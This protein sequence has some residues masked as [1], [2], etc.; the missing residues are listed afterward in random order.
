MHQHTSKNSR[1]DRKLAARVAQGDRA[2]FAEFID[3]YGSR[4]QALARRYATTHAD[5][6]DLI[7]EI[8]L[9]L[10]RNIASFRGESALST[11]VYRVA[12]NH[13]LKHCQRRRPELQPL[14]SAPEG[15]TDCPS[16]DPV[17]RVIAGELRE[18][19]QGALDGLS[20]EHRDVVVLHELHELTYGEC[21]E[22]LRVPV[23]TVKSRLHYAFRALKGSLA[24]YV[25][26]DSSP[27]ENCAGPPHS[28]AAETIG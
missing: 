23:G 17:G 5:A 26:G 14:D 21:A 27:G 2:A 6:E 10:Y 7:Q 25:L 12:L 15:A 18:K 22:I 3:L 20:Q 16:A 24:A 11:W 13:C 28:A 8:F 19:V 4:I 9:D 1:S